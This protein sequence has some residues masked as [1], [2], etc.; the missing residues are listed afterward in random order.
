MTIAGVEL[1]DSGLA[2]ASVAFA[3]YLDRESWRSP[4][5][6]RGAIDD[7]L[8]PGEEQGEGWEP[9]FYIAWVQP[10]VLRIG[11]SGAPAD[12]SRY[13]TATAAVT[14][15]VFVKRDKG[16]VAEHEVFRD[17]LEWT[18]KQ[19]STQDWATC[20]PAMVPGEPGWLYFVLA[21]TTLTSRFANPSHSWQ[22]VDAVADSLRSVGTR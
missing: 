5:R 15:I 19:R 12:T 18:I 1:S 11:R 8:Q 21:D 17:T 13:A 7:C 2:S 22:R 9:D 6:T 20:T 3:R 14:R 10:R 4:G 16:W